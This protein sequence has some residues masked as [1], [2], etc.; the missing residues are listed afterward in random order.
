MT[1]SWKHRNS[2]AVRGAPLASAATMAGRNMAS[3]TLA[4]R[5]V[6]ALG[7]HDGGGASRAYAPSAVEPSPAVAAV[8]I[9]IRRGLAASDSGRVNS[10]IPLS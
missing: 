4:A 6:N 8:P 3:E 1:L 2:F 9:A 7:R 5:V 10:N